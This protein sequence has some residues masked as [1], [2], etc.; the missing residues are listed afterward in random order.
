MLS[1]VSSLGYLR[2]SERSLSSK[3]LLLVPEDRHSQTVKPTQE[4]RSGMGAAPE[5]LILGLYAI[6]THGF[7]RPCMIKRSFFFTEEPGK[8]LCKSLKS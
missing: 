5:S 2:H 3:R 8:P 6:S 7:L 4:N 1:G